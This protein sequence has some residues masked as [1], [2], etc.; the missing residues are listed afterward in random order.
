[1][2]VSAES[3]DDF[4]FNCTYGEYYECPYAI[5]TWNLDGQ[6]EDDPCEPRQDETVSIQEVCKSHAQVKDELE[7][8][9]RVAAAKSK[10]QQEHASQQRSLK[11]RQ[12]LD[13]K[14]LRGEITEAK[15]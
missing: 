7:R 3:D 4:M 13:E 9:R 10:M 15:H 11:A 6:R 14:L 1:M 5:Q 8:R 2:L 12:D